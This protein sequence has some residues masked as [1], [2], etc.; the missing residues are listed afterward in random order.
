VTDPEFDLTLSTGEG[1]S[2]AYKAFCSIFWPYFYENVVSND[3]RA[4]C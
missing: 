4:K 3:S 1:E 2:V